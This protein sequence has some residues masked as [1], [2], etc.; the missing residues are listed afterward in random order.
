MGGV[1]HMVLLSSTV[2]STSIDDAFWQVEERL[3]VCERGRR[4]ADV[5]GGRGARVRVRLSE[6][7]YRQILCP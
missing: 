6:Q 1:L 3:C 2:S 4:W 5:G 7:N